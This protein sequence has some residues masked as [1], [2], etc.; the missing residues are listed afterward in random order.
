[1]VVLI[2]YEFICRIV[3]HGTLNIISTDRANHHLTNASIYLSIYQLD[4][5]YIPSRL[6]FVPDALLYLRVLG[7][8]IV[9]KDDV[10]PIL[11]VL[12]D[13]DPGINPE[14]VLLLYS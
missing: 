14:E 1:M 2:D 7:D 8:D 6:N 4:I 5:H 9:Y 3:H 13:E 10:E 12:W 11:D